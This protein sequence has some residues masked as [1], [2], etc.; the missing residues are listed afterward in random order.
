MVHFPVWAIPLLRAALSS[1]ICPPGAAL[2]KAHSQAHGHQ[3]P[4]DPPDRHTTP[5]HVSDVLHILQILHVF[6]STK[7]SHGE[8]YS[9]ALRTYK[10]REKKTDSI[11]PDTELVI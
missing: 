6:N 11:S 5:H 8:W 2:N 3:V 10:K 7:D 1:P 4:R 9:Y